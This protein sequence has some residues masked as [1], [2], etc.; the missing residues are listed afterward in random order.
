[1]IDYCLKWEKTLRNWT[2]DEENV[3]ATITINNYIK[4]TYAFLLFQMRKDIKEL[5]PVRSSPK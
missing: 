2:K 4:T 5:K 1:M 3:S